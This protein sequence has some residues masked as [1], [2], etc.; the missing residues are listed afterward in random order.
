[1]DFRQWMKCFDIYLRM[2]QD[3]WMEA[4]QLDDK[5]KYDYLS[6]SFPMEGLRIFLTNPSRWGIRSHTQN[7]VQDHFAPRVSTCIAVFPQ[8]EARGR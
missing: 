7:V 3:G 5:M 2:V 1:M 4:F 6:S 8:A